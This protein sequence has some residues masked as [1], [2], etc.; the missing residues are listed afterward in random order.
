MKK[1]IMEGSEKNG[2]E[3]K[4]WWLG[5]ITIS[6]IFTI[7]FSCVDGAA[8]EKDSASNGDHGAGCATA[9]GAGCGG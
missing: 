7:I 4:W 3:V 1:L 6:V 8:D 9:C 5:L 2:Y